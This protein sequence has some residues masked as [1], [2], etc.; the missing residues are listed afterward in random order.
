MRASEADEE[1]RELGRQVFQRYCAE[2][3][4]ATGDGYGLRQD[5]SYARPR[6]FQ[7]ARFKLATTDN[8]VPSDQDLI[9]TISR[10]MPGSGMPN[11]SHL[12]A[13]ELA[14]VAEHVR[15]IGVEAMRAGLERGVTEGRLGRDEADRILAARTTPGR[16]VE[17]P[18]E[19]A[20]SEADLRRGRELYLEACAACHGERGATPFGILT[21]DFDGNRLPPTSLRHGV[22]KGGAESEQIYV[23]ILEGMDGT[24][25]PGYE[26]VYGPEDL[27]RLVHYVQSL[28]APGG[29]P[30]DPPEADAEPATAT[31]AAG[32]GSEATS[33]APW[34]ASEMAA[35]PGDDAPRGGRWLV[36]LVALAAIGLAGLLLALGL[37]SAR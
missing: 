12:S 7:S 8:G 36:L 15:A 6:S 34:A 35:M 22:F 23:R 30:V 33:T 37:G 4:G 20:V 18:A 25:M 29:S 3:H 27:W 10:G 26:G 31:T 16:A 32:S 13:A 19:P 24:A 9:R 1:R 21:T 5:I 14:A 17:V 11:W 2:C 28:S